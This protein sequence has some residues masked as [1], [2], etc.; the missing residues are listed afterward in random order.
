VSDTMRGLVTRACFAE[1][2]PEREVAGV[3]PAPERGA[4]A[5]TRLAVSALRATGRAPASG[6]A[7]ARSLT[8]RFAATVSGGVESTG[9]DRWH[10]PSTMSTESAVAAFFQSPSRWRWCVDDLMPDRGSMAVN[11][12]E[13][14]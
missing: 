5:P 6:S 2:L 11:A 1:S 4:R 3:V 14:A 8:E 12:L 13:A 9:L 7:S 10:A